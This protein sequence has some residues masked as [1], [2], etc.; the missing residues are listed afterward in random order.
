MGYGHSPTFFGVFE[1]FE[2]SPDTDNHFPSG[3]N[4]RASIFRINVNV[5]NNRYQ[6]RNLS[7]KQNSASDDDSP[8]GPIRIR[9]VVHFLLISIR[10]YERTRFADKNRKNPINAEKLVNGPNKSFRE[11]SRMLSS[12]LPEL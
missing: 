3:N 10:S 7:W 11:R 2:A 8:L 5:Q 4:F 9:F 12:H 6:V 1:I